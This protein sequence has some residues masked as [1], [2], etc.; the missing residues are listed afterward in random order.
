MGMDGIGKWVWARWLA[1]AGLLASPVWPDSK[2]P[3]TPD[4]TYVALEKAIRD[5]P[6]E[7]MDEAWLIDR[8]YKAAPDPQKYVKLILGAPDLAAKNE[9]MARLRQAYSLRWPLPATAGCPW[10][11][12]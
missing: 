10:P 12:P 11:A 5:T 8:I 2:P 3:S 6:V 4:A 1:L 9:R 7:A